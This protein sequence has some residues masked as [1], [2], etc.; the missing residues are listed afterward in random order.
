M[1]F[2]WFWGDI[3]FSYTFGKGGNFILKYQHLI[4]DTLLKTDKLK[5][6]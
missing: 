2:V 4:Y 1:Y 3:N 6:T 5:K